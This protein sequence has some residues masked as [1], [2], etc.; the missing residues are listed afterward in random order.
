MN[1]YTLPEEKSILQLTN[2]NF[3]AKS[4]DFV[5][6][7]HKHRANPVEFEK[8]KKEIKIHHEIYTLNKLRD[9]SIYK[10]FP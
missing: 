8:K 5:D 2:K 10:Y 9:Q 6:N 3:L 1:F 4:K 7:Y